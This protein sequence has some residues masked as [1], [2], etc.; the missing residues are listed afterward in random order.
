LGTSDNVMTTNSAATALYFKN[1]SSIAHVLGLFQNIAAFDVSNVGPDSHFQAAECV[2][3]LCVRQYSS[4]VTNGKYREAILNTWPDLNSTVQNTTADKDDT[5]YFYEVKGKKYGMANDA[6]EN[7]SK[8]LDTLINGTVTGGPDPTFESDVL[9]PIWDRRSFVDPISN[10]SATMTKVIRDG[11]N[12]DA[13][14]VPMIG[15][16]GKAGLTEIYIDVRWRWIVVPVALFVATV[17]QL[18]MTIVRTRRT[19]SGVW[20]SSSLALAFHG[21]DSEAGEISRRRLEAVKGSQRK[22]RGGRERRE[23]EET[24]LDAAKGLKVRMVRMGDGNSKL[25]V[26]RAGERDF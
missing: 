19:G 1:A 25:V 2:L 15:A 23:N 3:Y 21:F 11:N 10:V 14:D 8:Y 9:Q 24:L 4:A 7:I 5:L 13:D 26:E 12:T 22:G 6:F 18:V 16:Q 17:V 20:R